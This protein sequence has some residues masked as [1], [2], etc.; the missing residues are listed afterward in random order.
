MI[1]DVRKERVAGRPC[2]AKSMVCCAWV[3]AE[4]VGV[5]GAC[6][7]VGVLVVIVCLECVFVCGAFV[8]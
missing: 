1:S 5:V 6:A 2:V 7:C 8:M 3:R 4:T